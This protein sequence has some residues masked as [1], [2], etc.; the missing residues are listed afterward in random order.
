VCVCVCVT[1]GHQERSRAFFK[2]AHN[3]ERLQQLVRL[4]KKG[5]GA[6]ERRRGGARA[7][8]RGAC[9]SYAVLLWAMC[10]YMPMRAA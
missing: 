5:A 4:L 3:Q 8:A 9:L 1:T 6:R 7:A 2:E 10:T